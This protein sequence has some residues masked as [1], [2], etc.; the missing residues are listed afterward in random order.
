MTEPKD[1]RL[2]E[3]MALVYALLFMLVIGALLS[4]AMQN[5]FT[6]QLSH[7]LGIEI[8]PQFFGFLSLLGALFAPLLALPFVR[9]RSMIVRRVAYVFTAFG[10]LLYI[11]PYGFWTFFGPTGSTITR[12]F[13]LLLMGLFGSFAVIARAVWR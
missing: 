4:L 11:F 1:Q 12:L 3:W 5:A 9:R 10:L 6:Q 7:D 2:V 13:A 8:T